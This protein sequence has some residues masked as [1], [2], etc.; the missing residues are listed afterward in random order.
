MATVRVNELSE[1]DNRS[2]HAGR[3]PATFF[4]GPSFPDR[5]SDVFVSYAIRKPSIPWWVLWALVGLGMNPLAKGDSTGQLWF[6]F[7]LGKLVNQH[8]YLELDL[9]PKIQVSGES[10]WRNLDATGL[11]EYYPNGWFDLTGELTLGRTHQLNGLNTFEVT[12][13]IG[14]RVHFLKQVME[15]V[16][17]ETDPDQGGKGSVLGVAERVPLER[18]D[19]GLYL[20]LESRHFHYSDDSPS[21]HNWRLRARLESKGSLNKRAL[22]EIGVL[23]GIA[24]VEQY[25]P[26][27]EDEITESFPNKTRVRLGLGYRFKA[28][29]RIEVLYIR[30]W[31]RD[32]ADG[33]ETE[34]GNTLDIRWKVQ[35]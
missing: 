25:I 20:R 3:L 16:K 7:T 26:L 22:N 28:S 32:S 4:A 35:F 5:V 10:S 23:Y 6:N 8:S 2:A 1:H 17:A 18:F 9:E 29:Q 33:E 13:R 24:D 19:V 14:L 31:H 11:Y 12:P 27:S 15:S 34:D 21:E 30:D